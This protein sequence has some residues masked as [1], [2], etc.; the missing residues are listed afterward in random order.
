M[1]KRISPNGGV[2]LLTLGRV[3]V[4]PRK[5]KRR[6]LGAPSLLMQ[7]LGAVIRRRRLKEKLLQ[8]SVAE[9]SD[10]DRVFYGLL[11]RG[12]KS[13]SVETLE[14]MRSGWRS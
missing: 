6:T 9:P 7:H 14:R 11:E 13:A 10:V 3:A 12:R 8:R 2:R 1:D 5:P 4:L